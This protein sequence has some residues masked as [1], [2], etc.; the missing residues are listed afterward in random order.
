ME[1]LSVKVT[2]FMTGGWVDDNPDCVKELVKRGHDLGNHS[3]HH[4]D[5]TTISQ[6]QK[7]SELQ[8]VYI[9]K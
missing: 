1:S 9:I 3:E 2:F 5:M 6:V 8:S 4:Y 7:D